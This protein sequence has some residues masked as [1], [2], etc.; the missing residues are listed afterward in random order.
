VSEEAPGNTGLNTVLVILCM[1]MVL[2]GGGC[3]MMLIGWPDFIVLIVVPLAI[4]V[5][6]VTMIAVLLD[7]LKGRYWPLFV[8]V[9][10]I[11]LLIAGFFFVA[12]G[13]VGLFQSLIPVLFVLK[14]VLSF[15]HASRS[16]GQAA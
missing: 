16:K 3:A 15:I 9:G 7:R 14:G 8:I 12:S 10:V 11:D 1:L 6:N 2:F 13:G 5:V 4:V